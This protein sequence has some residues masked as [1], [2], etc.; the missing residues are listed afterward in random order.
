MHTNR[1]SPK[2][3]IHV[4]STRM[5]FCQKIIYCKVFTECHFSPNYFLYPFCFRSM[6][7]CS[8]ITYCQGIVKGAILCFKN[9]YFYFWNGKS[10]STASP[11][12]SP[13]SQKSK[14]LNKVPLLLQ[15]LD[16]GP[17]W[18]YFSRVNSH[19]LNVLLLL[20]MITLYKKAFQ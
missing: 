5:N 15:D 13:A 4:W 12:T 3:T 20:F 19:L 6:K 7:Q 17:K 1:S 9:L 14:D 8:T 16:R 10:T 18:A 11:L 2:H